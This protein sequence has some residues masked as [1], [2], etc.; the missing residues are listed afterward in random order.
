MMLIEKYTINLELINKIGYGYASKHSLV[1]IERFLKILGSIQK[2]I[3]FV[4]CINQSD[5]L[6]TISPKENVTCVTHVG[7]NK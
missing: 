6:V 4:I 3:I 5:I 7:I 2:N 1:F